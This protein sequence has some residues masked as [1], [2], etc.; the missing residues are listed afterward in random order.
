M[1]ACADRRVAAA[2]GVDWDT[3]ATNPLAEPRSA[4]GYS[5]G[6]P[7]SATGLGNPAPQGGALPS[8]LMV[9]TVRDG[10]AFGSV[11]RAAGLA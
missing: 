5:G 11:R 2:G 1:R 9:E 7:R 8:Y 6:R 10:F 4:A 3:V